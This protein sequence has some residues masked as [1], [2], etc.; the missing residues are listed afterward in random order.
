MSESAKQNLLRSEAVREE[1]NKHLWI[2]SEKAGRDIG[3]EN[4]VRD[5]LKK[6][7]AEWIKNNMGG[8]KSPRKRRTQNKPS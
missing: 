2:E 3:Y 8:E 1:I 6:F 7:S 5:W 4:A